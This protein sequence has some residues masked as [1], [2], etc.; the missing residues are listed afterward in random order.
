[1]HKTQK[2]KALFFYSSLPGASRV[3]PSDMCKQKYMQCF[4]GP[5][6]GGGVALCRCHSKLRLCFLVLYNGLGCA[7]FVPENKQ[8]LAWSCPVHSTTFVL[9]YVL[10]LF[11]LKMI[12]G[13][14]RGFFLCR[15]LNLLILVLERFWWEFFVS[16]KQALTPSHPW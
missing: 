4:T 11:T 5:L 3:A 10:E 7:R 8:Y 15:W 9:E 14:M 16:S 2:N 6:V 12:L 1:M 13:A